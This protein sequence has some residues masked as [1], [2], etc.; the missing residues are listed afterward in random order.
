LSGINNGLGGS[1]SVAVNFSVSFANAGTSSYLGQW[2]GSFSAFAGDSVRPWSSGVTHSI[3]FNADF[4]SG[5]NK[6]WFDAT[7]GDNGSDK[8]GADWD[9]VTVM[10][11]EIGH[12]L[13]FTSLYRDNVFTLGETNPWTSRIVS[14]VFDPTGLNVEM[15]LGDPAHVLADP[16]LMDTT[17]SNTEGR[18]GISNLEAQM[19]VKAYGYTLTAVPE[20][21]T[22]LLVMACGPIGLFAFRRSARKPIQAG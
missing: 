3:L 14:N 21:S 12:M 5:A 11:H 17:L 20:P 13:G 18:I 7:P 22:L 16:L 19:L 2:S 8:A 4:L 10:R 9:A 1:T 15:E 6:L